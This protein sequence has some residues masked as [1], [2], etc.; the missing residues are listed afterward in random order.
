[1]MALTVCPLSNF[2][3][4]GVTDMRAHPIKKMLELGLKATINSDDPAYFGGYVNE[5]YMAIAESLDLTKGEILTLAR[6]GFEASFCSAN[7][8]QAMIA[9]LDAYGA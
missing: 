4:A 2:K 3:L 7:E 5:N 9:K 1:D 6:N 8:K